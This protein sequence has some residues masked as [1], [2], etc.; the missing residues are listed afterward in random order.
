MIMCKVNRSGIRF[1]DESGKNFLSF[2]TKRCNL[3]TTDT[4]SNFAEP[5]YV[6]DGCD[7]NLLKLA[8][9]FISQ[10]HEELISKLNRQRNGNVEAKNNK[11]LCKAL[12]KQIGGKID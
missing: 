8:Y 11:E 6:A 12:F 1:Y 3:I 10:K 7:A 9:V 4:L 5:S 2:A